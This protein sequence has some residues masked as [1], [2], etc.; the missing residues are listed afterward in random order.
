MQSA[1]RNGTTPEVAGDVGSGVFST[2]SGLFVFLLMM[3]FAVQLTF[4]LYAKSQV[5][6]ITFAAARSI[7]TS[8]NASDPAFQ[9]ARRVIAQEYLARVNA[10]ATIAL[11]PA[12]AGF[13]R[14]HV[15]ARAKM[16][17]AGSFGGLD[18]VTAVDR[19]ID[20]RI[21]KVQP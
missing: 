6:A 14:L 15:R 8:P 19:I 20:V 17:F 9:E 5:T 11:E 1:N 18:G 16:I 2:T 10:N 13:I 4:G 21:E 7:A 12:P 3:L